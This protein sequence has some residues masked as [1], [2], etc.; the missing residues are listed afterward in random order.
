M[1]L[2]HP[3]SLRHWNSTVNVEPGFL[4]QV[5]EKLQQVPDE[6]KDCAF[7]FDGMA[8]RQQLIWSKA[9]HKCVGYCDYGNN[10]NFDE[11]ETEA[12]ETLVFMVVNLKGKWKWP[13]AYFL[14]NRLSSTT[15]AELIKTAL[16]L[17]SNIK[18]RIRSITCDGESVNVSAL[19]CLGCNLF[20]NNQQDIINFFIHPIDNYK[21]YIIL[22]VCHMLK[23]TRNALADY[24]EF[25]Y[26]EEVI[27]WD[28]IVSLY[29]IQKKLTFKLKNKLS[30]Q[31][32]YWKQNKMKV[33]FAANTLSASVANAIDFLR[34]EGLH[35]F[36]ESESTTTF[37]RTID[38]LF[39]FLN[40]RN[41]FEKHF[42]QPITVHNYNYLQTIMENNI[43][44]L[45]S[46]K[47]KDGNYLKTSRRKTFLYGF[48]IAVKSILSVAHDLLFLPNTLYKYILTYKFS[49]DAIELFF[50]KLRSCNGYNNN[51]NALQ[52]QYAMRKLLLRNSIKNSNNGNCLEIN[53]DP[54][55]SVFDFTW[56]KKQKVN[57]LENIEVEDEEN[58]EFNNEDELDEIEYFNTNKL[59]DIDIL[60]E[61]IL[62]YIGGYVVKKL[63][64]NINCYSCAESLLNQ[65]NVECNSNTLN[66]NFYKFLDF[67]NN[68]GLVR[69][70]E[71]VYKIILE[72]EKQIK[73]LTNNFS[74]FLK[75]L[76]LKVI[77]KVKNQF[78]LNNHIFAN[79]NCENTDILETPHKI[80][81]ITIIAYRYANIRLYVFS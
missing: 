63:I 59:N 31:C 71:S 60:Q 34:N 81:L 54:V 15:L 70:S 40:S 46:L 51:P 64:R 65:N 28:Y 48:A 5:L 66:Q 27:K 24:G 79:L 2:P 44:Y 38:R 21:V 80:K 76:D 62:C 43:E 52:L 42:K 45:F 30:S 17:T 14:K 3:S 39:D 20:P 8:I 9:D 4:S 49:Q 61:N 13:I 50:Q 78:A 77:M 53:N 1:T 11:N 55:G 41:P 18:L 10:F 74:K 67:N 19:N 75:N 36:K 69:P 35:D 12:K 7:I 56:K 22:D 26:G 33:R 16:I 25:Y 29:K 6:D 57:L 23:L 72:T 47:C 58:I 32:I 73:L 68:G 37:V